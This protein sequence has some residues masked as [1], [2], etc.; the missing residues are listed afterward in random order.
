MLAPFFGA[1]P[2]PPTLSMLAYCVF[3]IAIIRSDLLAILISLPLF[4]FA[5]ASSKL[6]IDKP[7]RRKSSKM[8][9]RL[10]FGVLTMLAVSTLWVFATIGN[11]MIF[12]DL[13]V[14]LGN[15]EYQTDMMLISFSRIKFLVVILLGVCT[16][17]P[18][19]RRAEEITDG[20]S[21]VMRA[22]RDYGSMFMMLIIFLFTVVFF[23]PQ[24]EVY[25]YVPFN[26]IVM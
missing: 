18:R 26:Y 1:R 6:R 15:A 8:G 10:L 25:S 5:L 9:L 20:L 4:V 11:G 14:D 13:A 22:I 7:E 21:P 17:L 19:T 16:I 2:V 12:E 3:T 23:L 24:F